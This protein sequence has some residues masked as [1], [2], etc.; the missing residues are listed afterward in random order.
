MDIVAQQKCTSTATSPHMAAR[1]YPLAHTRIANN[2]QL[3]NRASCQKCPSS[4]PNPRQPR[5]DT[6]PLPTSRLPPEA[7]VSVVIIVRSTCEYLLVRSN[8]LAPATCCQPGRRRASMAGVSIV[9]TL[10]APEDPSPGPPSTMHDD[11]ICPDRRP[12][13]HDAIMDL[14]RPLH[15]RRV[16][17]ITSTI[18]PWFVS[19][20]PSARRTRRQTDSTTDGGRHTW[21][22]RKVF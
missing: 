18:E 15:A 5:R 3:N 4:F 2:Y 1:M 12:V 8:L 20:P 19:G 10:G 11:V 14:S 6:V 16:H 22:S 21:S 13:S 17:N 9:Q 7:A